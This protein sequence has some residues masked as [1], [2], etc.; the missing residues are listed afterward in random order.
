MKVLSWAIEGNCIELIEDL[1]DDTRKLIN[2]TCIGSNRE[3]AS[4][5]FIAIKADCAIETFEALLGWP[6]VDVEIRDLKQRTPLAAASE[7]GNTKIVH[8]L[9]QKGADT[10]A[11]DRERQTPLLKALSKHHDEVVKELLSAGADIHEPRSISGGTAL[12]LSLDCSFEVIELL[13]RRGADVNAW[14]ATGRR[15]LVAAVEMGNVDAVDALLNNG[16]QL[17]CSNDN[18]LPFDANPLRLAVS[19]NKKVMAE[20]LLQ[21][22]SKTGSPIDDRVLFLAVSS[23]YEE[24]VHHLLKYGAN[25]DIQDSSG[26]TPLFN[27]IRQGNRNIA[28]QLLEAGARTDLG[29]SD[30]RGTRSPFC[31]AVEDKSTSFVQLL[32]EYKGRPSTEDIRVAAESGNYNLVSS[33]LAAR[34]ELLSEDH[35]YSVLLQTATEEWHGREGE[36]EVIK[37][38]IK[39]RSDVTGKRIENGEPYC[40]ALQA[41]SHRGREDIV[42]VLL[43]AGADLNMIGG[44][45]GTALHAAVAGWDDDIMVEMLLGNGGMADAQ[46]GMHGTALHAAIYHGR[47]RTFNILLGSGPD[48]EARDRN[49]HTPLLA[50]VAYNR[51]QMARALLEAGVDIEAKDELACTPLL[52][53][54]SK[55]LEDITRLLLKHGANVEAQD[56]KGRTAFLLAIDEHH[57]TIIEVLLNADNKSNVNVLGGIYGSPLKAAMYWGDQTLQMKLLQAGAKQPAGHSDEDIDKDSYEDSDW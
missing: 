57:E 24:I 5:L 35:V 19:D 16:A 1:W 36:L 54:V 11:K 17:E 26:S 42:D 43:Q 44:E 52:V 30:A 34:P 6:G 33:L 10:E 45:Y 12:H 28:T 23:S 51:P 3:S 47:Q 31:A 14:D 7:E 55:G 20:R 22:Y 37:Q 32:L 40:N 21:A 13:L 46:G 4:P 48:F 25:V 18:F 49:M 15:P 8:L 56:A 27:A 50:T 2:V 41:A 29:P 9:L 39:A 38:L 53:V